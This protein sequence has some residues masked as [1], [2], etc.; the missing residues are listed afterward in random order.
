MYI[1]AYVKCIRVFVYTSSVLLPTTDIIWPPFY[2]L[3]I[4]HIDV[5]WEQRKVNVIWSL[6]GK[7]TKLVHSLCL[8]NTANALLISLC[9]MVEWMREVEVGMDS[10][11]TIWKK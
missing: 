10:G 1:I 8:A 7:T 5:W 6:L 2:L 3:Y 4:V 11:G 9:D